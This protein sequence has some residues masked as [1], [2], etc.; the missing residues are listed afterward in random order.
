M[1][2]TLQTAAN[3][4]RTARAPK[5]FFAILRRVRSIFSF[6]QERQN[7]PVRFLRVVRA[8]RDGK[9]VNDIRSEFGCSLNTINR[10][11]RMAELPK[12]PKSD[13][14]A[15]RA[16]IIRLSKSNPR[17]SQERIAKECECSVALVSLVEHEAG[18]PRYGKRP[19]RTKTLSH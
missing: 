17:P 7:R 19:R 6:E 4:L 12:R 18:L 5:A 10:Y 11:A 3:F 16:K 1:N 13:D 9:P 2:V 14:P 8:Y 15:R